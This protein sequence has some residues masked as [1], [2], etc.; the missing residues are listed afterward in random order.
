M[1]WLLIIPWENQKRIFCIS[2]PFL[3][4]SVSAENTINSVSLSSYS[5]SVSAENTIN[6]VSY[7]LLLSMTSNELNSVLKLQD[8]Q[9]D[10][11]WG[12]SGGNRP[13]P[14]QGG[15]HITAAIFFM[16]FALCASTNCEHVDMFCSPSSIQKIRSGNG[17]GKIGL[18]G[19]GYNVVLIGLGSNGYHTEMDQTVRV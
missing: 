7:I 5:V 19:V 2:Y 14:E 9:Q 6:S 11:A 16:S 8:E 12:C 4:L 10:G 1:L 13:F 17:V 3:L 15:D 18:F